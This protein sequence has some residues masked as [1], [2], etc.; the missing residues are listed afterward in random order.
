MLLCNVCVSLMGKVLWRSL[1]LL[2]LYFLLLLLLLL[3][4]L[5]R[6]GAKSYNAQD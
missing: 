4:L 5:F 2:G 3:L 6:H 1:L